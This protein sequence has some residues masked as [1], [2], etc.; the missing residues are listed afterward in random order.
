MKPSLPSLLRSI[1]LLSILGSSVGAQFCNYNETVYNGTT[2]GI[3][4]WPQDFSLDATKP[5][6]IPTSYIRPD[7]GGALLPWDLT[8]FMLLLHIPLFI[9]RIVRFD[10]AQLISII[11]AALSLCFTIQAFVSTR[12]EPSKILVWM[13]LTSVVDA[14]NMLH[15]ACLV[16][17]ENREERREN[18]ASSES[19]EPLLHAQPGHTSQDYL[20]TPPFSYQGS[21]EYF[22]SPP[23]AQ[24]PSQESM[25]S[26]NVSAASDRFDPAEKKK[27]KRLHLAVL[28]ITIALFLGI[29]TL[30]ITGLVWA[31]KER[32]ETSFTVLNCSPG[33]FGFSLQTENCTVL[34]IIAELDKGISCVS[35]PGIKQDRWITSTII[36]LIL[37]LGCEATDFVIIQIVMR[38]KKMH[39]HPWKRP[40]LTFVCGLIILTVLLA[41]GISDTQSL[42]M[43]M[44]SEVLIANNITGPN[45]ATIDSICKLDLTG[46]GLRGNTLE[47]MD[48][49]FNSWGCNC[50]FYHYLI[51]LC[52]ETN[53]RID[54]G[55]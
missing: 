17:E 36:V 11:L 34:P 39:E 53:L 10:K 43:G 24:Y 54:Y 31:I 50:Q 1:I 25:R 40:M 18:R 41:D 7:I 2:S 6:T 29:I 46:P 38:K 32:F 42:P 16:D 5:C 19:R 27:K 44:S 23:L 30:Q 45:G 21:Q 28:V 52:P 8:A 9:V 48:G 3:K 14:G 22:Q 51:I 49:I 47:W 20:M 35:L 33:F 15:I 26:R 12:L 4:P 37:V 13:P 55:C